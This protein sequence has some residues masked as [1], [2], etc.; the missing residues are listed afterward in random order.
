MQHP[1]QRITVFEVAGLFNQAFR[2]AATLDIALNGFRA[3]GLWPYNSD[4]FQQEDFGPMSEQR[5]PASTAPVSNEPCINGMNIDTPL[6]EELNAALN[7]NDIDIDL[8]NL[9][10]FPHGDI[11]GVDECMNTGSSGPSLQESSHEEMYTGED[12]STFRITPTQ[13]DGRCLFRSIATGIITDL[14]NA[15]RDQH[16]SLLDNGLNQI[17]TEAAD[18]IRNSLV[19][20]MKT[21][22]DTFREV[23]EGSLN[24]DQ[25]PWIHF[26]CIQD[27]IEFMHEPTAMPGELEVASLSCMLRRPI[28]ILNQE[29][30]NFMAYGA[31]SNDGPIYLQY[32]MIGEAAGHYEY[33]QPVPAYEA[34]RPNAESTCI[35]ISDS[36][37]PTDLNKEVSP[38]S[39]FNPTEKMQPEPYRNLIEEV[40]PLPTARTP[41]RRKRNTE[42]AALLTSPTLKKRLIEKQSSRC[43][44]TQTK[45]KK[46][47]APKHPTSAAP[48]SR[49]IEA[50]KQVWF[51]IICGD[52]YSNSRPREK[53]VLCQGDC[54][55]WAHVD[56]TERSHKFLCPHCE[57]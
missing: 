51:C 46:T 43:K 41:R 14:Q 36:P 25:P 24:A 8:D 3:C 9:D 55:E 26:N 56:C 57:E 29:S 1:S 21:N 28:H 12:M 44:T 45:Q 6:I 38:D 35:Y 49:K 47:T 5:P 53:W 11:S 27:R 40:S 39:Q 42:G 20:Y 13:A 10:V 54:N 48:K 7:L 4:I 32:S 34:C 33:M 37:K 30:G 15:P 17:E 52:T 50:Q 16:G 22:I 31:E 2:K 23:S 18:Q 19:D